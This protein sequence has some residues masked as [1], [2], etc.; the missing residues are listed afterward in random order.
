MQ[1]LSLPLRGYTASP[2]KK[3]LFQC[4]PAENHTPFSPQRVTIPSRGAGALTMSI[5]VQKLV[6][7]L[8]N[9]GLQQVE[10]RVQ[11]AILKVEQ[12]SAQSRV[13]DPH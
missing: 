6:D 12:S 2:R 3:I 9:G 8:E 7:I 13:A 10:E 11:F 5:F 1:S 4:S